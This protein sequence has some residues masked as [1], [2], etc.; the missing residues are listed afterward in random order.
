MM[1]ELV[2]QILAPHLE[3]HIVGRV[4]TGGDLRAAARRYRADVLI[5]LQPN[6]T[7]TN[8]GADRMFYRRPLRVLAITHGGRES[9]L[10]VLRPHRSALGEL[11]ADS[12]VAAIR[13]AGDA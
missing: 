4:P 2:E 7:V 12:L 1:I 3:F 10:Y 9:V 13:D 8:A 6:N 11:S 5:V